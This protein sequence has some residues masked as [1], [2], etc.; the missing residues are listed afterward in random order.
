MNFKKAK[1]LRK[2]ILN[3]RQGLVLT[4]LAEVVVL[5]IVLAESLILSHGEL[6]GLHNILGVSK[7]IVGESDFLQRLGDGDALQ[8]F[9]HTFFHKDVTGEVDLSQ[10]RFGE[11]EDLEESLGT[12]GVDPAVG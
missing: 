4:W 11:D 6:Q 1:Q 9:D 3:L 10:G 7:L 8:D 2:S 12:L 5:Q